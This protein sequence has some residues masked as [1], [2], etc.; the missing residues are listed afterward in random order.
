MMS[1]S[2]RDINRYLLYSYKNISLTDIGCSVNGYSITELLEYGLLDKLNNY[3]ESF[4]I[5]YQESSINEEYMDI[6]IIW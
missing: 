4:E 5:I 3:F 6:W 2:K 1:C